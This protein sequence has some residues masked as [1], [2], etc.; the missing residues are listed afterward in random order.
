MTSAAHDVSH[1]LP[2]LPRLDR[3]VTPRWLR[4]HRRA[5]A[6]AARPEPVAADVV[7]EILSRSLPGREMTLAEIIRQQNVKPFD[8]DE[9]QRQDSGLTSEDWA[10]LRAALGLRTEW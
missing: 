6:R 3:M 8:W 10:E 9:Y 7:Q 4:E 5:V 1:R 2:D